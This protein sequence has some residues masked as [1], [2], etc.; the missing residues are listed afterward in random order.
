MNF[1]AVI[2]AG[3]KSSRMGR[4]KGLLEV[5][6][7]SLLARQIKLVRAAG[8]SE[9][10]ISGRTDNNYADFDCPVLLDRFPDSGPLSGIQAALAIAT[11][12]RLLVLAVDMPLMKASVFRSLLEHCTESAGAVPRVNRAIEPLTAFYPKAAASLAL[13]LLNAQTGMPAAN[14]RAER[15]TTSPYPARDGQDQG[16][17]AVKF[18]SAKHF[19]ECCIAAELATF[20]ELPA[21]HTHFFTNWNSPADIVGL[22]SIA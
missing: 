11:T 1:S 5:D 18:P 13:E 19:A 4:D 14:S 7:Q 15:K 8:A 2:L 22:S 6:G 21:Q 12:P 16:K 9:V 17:Q 10:F 3:G 20:V